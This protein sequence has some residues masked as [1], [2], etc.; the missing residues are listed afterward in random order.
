MSAIPSRLFHP[1]PEPA[2]GGE[3]DTAGLAALCQRLGIRAAEPAAL[4]AAI[5]AGFPVRVVDALARELDLPIGELLGVLGL[6]PATLSRRRR[7]RKSLT[8][9]E[10]DRVYRIL[11]VWLAA[12]RLFEGDE[13]AARHWLKRPARAL[14]GVSPL[15]QLDTEAGADAVRD[16]I[17]RLEHGVVT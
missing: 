4:V 15:S 17:G 13:G 8:P 9:A 11:S 10:S 16:L 3:H 12:L 14:G 1:A 2:R 5:R 7:A 6:A